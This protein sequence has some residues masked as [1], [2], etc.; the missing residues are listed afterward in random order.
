MKEASSPVIILIT[1]SA[2]LQC[3]FINQKEELGRKPIKELYTLKLY[4]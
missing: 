1:E 2:I 3:R 4:E